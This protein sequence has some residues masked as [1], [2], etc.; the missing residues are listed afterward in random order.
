[1]P[2]RV[3]FSRV[4]TVMAL[5]AVLALA[6]AWPATA[7]DHHPA[8]VPP[9]VEQ[10]V[11]AGLSRWVG[12]LASDPRSPAHGV[13]DPARYTA[14]AGHS[15]YRLSRFVQ[16][17][18]VATTLDQLTEPQ[19]V[20]RFVIELDGRPVG[21]AE[22]QRQG[23][24]WTVTG[25]A[26]DGAGA[27]GGPSSAGIADRLAQATAV[28]AEQG[29]AADVRW[30]DHPPLL[31]GLAGSDGEDSLFISL[32]NHLGLADGQTATLGEVSHRIHQAAMTGETPA[33]APA[34]PLATALT[35]V[36][37]LG[38]ALVAGGYLWLRRAAG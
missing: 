10:A 23:R 20:Y 34:A 37:V 1:M 12:V 32:G 28:L 22:V 36:G 38:A 8:Q 19:D 6:G 24:Q 35:G 25:V 17:G 18:G 5:A 7:V 29:L 27:E 21:I 14:D 26:Y 31:T 11:R 2:Q 4:L 13:E 30:I 9:E 16:Q 33:A 15:V 3:V